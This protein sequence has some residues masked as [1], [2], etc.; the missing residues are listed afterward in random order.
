MKELREIIKEELKNVIVEQS[1]TRVSYRDIFEVLSKVMKIGHPY[2]GLIKGEDVVVKIASTTYTISGLLQLFDKH[3]L[4]DMDTNMGRLS[5]GS[6]D[7]IVTADL[8][9]SG[10]RAWLLNVKAKNESFGIDITYKKTHG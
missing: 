3:K 2:E 1:N 10:K 8:T 6:I 9:R 7:V 5:D 4:S